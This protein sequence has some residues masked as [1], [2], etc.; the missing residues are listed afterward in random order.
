MDT[1]KIIKIFI[2]YSRKDTEFLS[3]LKT[4]L[5][6]LERNQS[7]KIWYDGEIIPGQV[8]ENEIKQA[9]H[10]AEIFLLLV[11]ANSLASDYFYNKE[12]S[13]ALE[14]HHKGESIVIPVILKPSGWRET[15]LAL[16]Q[17]LPQNGKPV[18]SWNNKDEAYESI[19]EG[20][21]TAIKNIQD[22]EYLKNKSEE[23]QK[24]LQKKIEEQKQKEQTDNRLWEEAVKTN[25]IFSYTKYIDGSVTGL[26]TDEAQQLTKELEAEQKN[27]ELEQQLWERTVTENTLSAYAQYLNEYS[28]SNYKQDALAAISKL[29]EIEKKDQEILAEKE[30]ALI[31]Q[32][33]RLWEQVTG[34][35]T[36]SSYRKYLVETRIGLFKEKAQQL[37][38]QLD[39][40]RKEKGPETQF[41]QIAK[42]P[43]YLLGGL[44]VIIALFLI[45]KNLPKKSVGNTTES[46]SSSDTINYAAPDSGNSTTE[47]S[48]SKRFSENKRKTSNSD[49]KD[50]KDVKQ[51]N[52]VDKPDPVPDLKPPTLLSPAD[53]EVFNIY[54]RHT[55][56]IWSAVKNAQSYKVEIEFDAGPNWSAY[57]LVAT[58]ETTY[59]FDFIGAQSGRWRVSTVYNDGKISTPSPW[60]TF[61]HLK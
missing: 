36:I 38:N 5:W 51:T 55:V 17:A 14:R 29:E 11:S 24:Q 59:S 8:W 12:V 60:R 52:T 32:E 9:L 19:Y 40:R 2:A 43:W 31:A 13:N 33:N 35:N 26:H 42:T 46:A 23:E 6:P 48:K 15:D 58:E 16:L 10:T 22:K 30:R 57:P 47:S 61:K 34:V 44:V 27:K 4:F 39:A 25:S 18:T 20:L 37:I 53:N 7:I 3:D 41:R 49:V 1:S 50:G 54:P 21:K 56:L 45:I 28:K